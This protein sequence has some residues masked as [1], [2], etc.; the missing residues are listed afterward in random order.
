MIRIESIRQR[1]ARWA[2]LARAVFLAAACIAAFALFSREG[3]NIVKALALIQPYHAAL[4]FVLSIG[5][6]F[7]SYLAWRVIIAW[8]DPQLTG[9]NT[10]RVFFLGQIGKYLPGGIW[11]FLASAEFGRDAG[12][13]SRTTMVSLVLALLINLGSGGILCAIALPQALL[14]LPVGPLWLLAAIAATA[15]LLHPAFIRKITG[16]AGI[17]LTPASGKMF[18]AG[19]LSVITWL[20]AGLHLIILARGMGMDFHAIDLILFAAIYA[21]AWIA[22]F[23]FMIAPAGLGAREAAMIALLATQMPLAE[24]TAIALLSR[25]L[26]TLADFT[27]AGATLALTRNRA[28]R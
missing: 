14:Q 5:H 20:F 13:K 25:L 1:F 16:V 12:L 10:A 28:A 8:H 23:V 6:I 2:W 27:L 22:G 17:D 26:M 24:A 11:P 3:A 21:F 9:G 18:G 4:A 19:I 15:I 7:A